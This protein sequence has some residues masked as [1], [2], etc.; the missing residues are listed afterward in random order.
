MGEEAARKY[1]YGL[2]NLIYAESEAWVP[3]EVTILGQEFTAAWLKG[4]EQWRRLS[5]DGKAKLFSIRESWKRYAP[6]GR[7]SDAD[8]IRMD[9]FPRLETVY[10]ES[11]R[12]TT[13]VFI[14]AGEKRLLDVLS[15]NLDNTS[16]RNLLGVL[17][18]KF[19]LYN[20]AEREF[21]YLLTK[22]DTLPA[23]VNLANLRLLQ[24]RN[25]DAPELYRRADAI[26]PDNPIV[27][28][29]LAKVMYPLRRFSEVDE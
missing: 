5:G 20:K 1:F 9:F 16:A 10:R 24:G 13:E 7:K 19:E 15:K 17:Y 25:G 22:A 11:L 2:E 14:G 28:V 18:A 26:S 4:A 8:S 6:V 21:T 12:G 23:L 3:V 29:G 27:L